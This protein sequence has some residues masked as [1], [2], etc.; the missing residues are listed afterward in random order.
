MTSLFVAN[1]SIELSPVTLSIMLE[2][3][4]QLHHMQGMLS[5]LVDLYKQW[6][7]QGVLWVLE[8]PAPSA[9][10]HAIT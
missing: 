10:T 9:L 7:S 1:I 2:R 5:I 6:N 8:H 3:T 4:L